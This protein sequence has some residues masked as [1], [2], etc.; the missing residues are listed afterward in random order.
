MWPLE[1][2]FVLPDGNVLNFVEY[3]DNIPLPVERPSDEWAGMHATVRFQ[4]STATM[5]DGSDSVASFK[6]P[7]L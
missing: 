3:D 7:R 6:R 4:Q 2:C 1:V 5:E